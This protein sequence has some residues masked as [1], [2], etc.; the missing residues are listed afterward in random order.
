VIYFSAID[1]EQAVR[2]VAESRRLLAEAVV[3]IQRQREII[4]RLEH[5][6]VDADKQRTLLTV[7]LEAQTREEKRAVEALDWIKTILPRKRRLATPPT[8]KN[9][10]TRIVQQREE[11]SNLPAQTITR[12][13]RS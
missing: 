1:H 5:L 8:D 6:G 9:D 4:A 11:S 7:L 3:R 2:I 13:P 12:P 10:L